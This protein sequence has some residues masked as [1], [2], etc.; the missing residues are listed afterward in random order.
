MLKSGTGGLTKLGLGILTLSGT[1][2]YSG[3][4][5]VNQGTLQLGNVA[6]LGTGGITIGSSG[7][8]DLNSF[9]LTLPS[10]SGSTGAVITDNSTPAS[11]PTPTI[12][13]V[14]IASGGSAYA[15]SVTK[16]LNGQDIALIKGGFGT[17]NLSGS[18]TYT[19]GTT[20]NQGSLS[21]T[22]K[23]TGG[24]VLIAGGA[25][26]TG[27]GSV[28]SS[29][30]GSIGSSITATGNL[31][32]GDSTSY[33]GF[34]H[35][36][37]LI[38]GSNAVTLNTRGFANLGVLTTLSGG[39]LT[40]P[41][42]VTIPLGGNLVG[43]GTV[44]GAV[45]AGIGSTIEATDN[46]V[47]GDSNSYDGFFSDGRLYAGSHT[48]TIHSKSQAAL[49]SLTTLAGGTLSVAN[50]LSLDF[51]HSIVGNGVV[52]STNLLAKATIINGSVYATDGKLTL[53]GFVK[54]VGTYSGSVSFAGTYSP[55][56]S[57]ASVNLEYL[58]LAPSSTLLMEVGGL[59][60]GSQY[61]VLNLSE[62]GMLDG[63]LELDLINKFVPTLGQTFDI[64]NGTT[65]GHF[66]SLLL[67]PLPNGLRW[68]TSNLYT[69][70]VISVVPEPSTLGLLGVAVI[71]LLGWTLLRF[72]STGLCI[73]LLIAFAGSAQASTYRAIDLN[74]SGFGASE[75][76]GTSGSQQVGYVGTTPTTGARAVLWSGDPTGYVDLNPAGYIWSIA[77]AT[78]GMQQV[79]RGESP[80]MSG[81]W[82]AL[83]WSGSAATYIDLNP[84]GYERTS[85]LDVRGT[86]QVGYGYVGTGSQSHALLWKGS[87][88]NYVDLSPAGFYG[89]QAMGTNGTQQVG[90]ADTTPTGGAHAML[91]SSSASAY[92]DLN[93][94]GFDWS[95]AN[96][97]YG[98]QQVGRG[99]TPEMGGVWHA[100]LWNGTATSYVD[101]H[102]SGFVHS[103]A[104]DTNGIQQVGYGFK[105]GE[106]VH[107]ILWSGTA[108]SA[109]DLNQFLPGGYTSAYAN[110]IDAGGNIVGYAND[111]GGNPHA[112]LWQPVPE[113]STLA[114]LIVGTIGLV[115][116][117]WSRRRAARRTVNPTAFDQV[118]LQDDSPAILAMPS[119]WPGAARRAA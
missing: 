58:S 22:G 107:A 1:N 50:G 104:L 36:G 34:N 117:G 65:T 24:S 55:G 20:I 92:I 43:S 21:V 71:G 109:V 39:T 41:N 56:L 31:S 45:A 89:S 25:T 17:L 96:E 77:E 27:S 14:N 18:S 91:W 11:Q 81:S 52:E 62:A 30:A 63:T 112:I 46:L 9:G 15:G 8:V 69:T 6:A 76:L 10:V 116:Y 80:E 103:M 94:P 32:L 47:L 13:A 111:S 70:G 82:H 79:G 97:I 110:A 51:A 3:G 98:T 7:T 49:G 102:P 61:D 119:R 85:A 75:A 60:A 44:N 95:I 64:I 23:L 40:A 2:T 108:E 83:L 26:L 93:P 28:N 33:T 59:S 101:L 115:G 16:G 54:G 86:E 114:L 84:N 99:E 35:A 38:V 4:T 100:L 12:L 118:E 5:T 105:W 57:P 78:N 19:G 67:A 113:P 88:A 68:N 48:V 53:T 87:A 29:I 74:P 37:S 73:A 90:Y 72:R 106:P 42:G 66:S